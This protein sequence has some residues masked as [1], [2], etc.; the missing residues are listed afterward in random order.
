[1]DTK[2]CEMRHKVAEL[3][4]EMKFASTNRKWNWIV[5]DSLLFCSGHRIGWGWWKTTPWLHCS[6]KVKILP[7]LV[8]HSLS[9]EL[10]SSYTQYLYHT[11]V[12]TSCVNSALAGISQA[13]HWW[14]PVHLCSCILEHLFATT[15]VDRMMD[16]I[17]KNW[18]KASLNKAPGQ[19][20]I[21]CYWNDP[22]SQKH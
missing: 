2:R 11:S 1:M 19:L 21:H 17:E 6:D 9:L 16:Y 22:A 14:L 3:G 12:A 15:Y 5:W 8:Q 10:K 4:G 18:R 13:P 7:Y 20:S